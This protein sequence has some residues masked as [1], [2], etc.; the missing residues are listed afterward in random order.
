MTHGFL[1]PSVFPDKREF[2]DNKVAE[3]TT[4]KRVVDMLR[5][6]ACA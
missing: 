5:E 1:D 2:L 6:D 3:K 4:P